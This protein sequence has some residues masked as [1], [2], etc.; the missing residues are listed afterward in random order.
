[1]RT[2]YRLINFWTKQ[3]E[4]TRLDSYPN[5]CRSF[6]VTERPSIAFA[7]ETERYKNMRS[8][9]VSSLAAERKR[10]HAVVTRMAPPYDWSA[11]KVSDHNQD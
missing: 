9:A 5:A 3:L 10:R 2:D 7:S 11:H 4:Y 8:V 1:M 6:V